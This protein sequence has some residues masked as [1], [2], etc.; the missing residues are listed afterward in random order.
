MPTVLGPS[1]R[2]PGAVGV[3][4]DDGRIVPLPP[5][6]V[7]R[8][9]LPEFQAPPSV[10][11]RGPELAYN[12]AT[13]PATPGPVSE[14]EALSRARNVMAPRPGAQNGPPMMANPVSG[15][16]I[17]VA[18][19]Q[20]PAAPPA[21]RVALWSGP[22]S[23]QQAQAPLEAA[24]PPVDPVAAGAEAAARQLGFA[25]DVYQQLGGD[26]RSAGPPSK[27]TTETTRE[28]KVYTPE[29]RARLMELGEKAEAA[30]TREV[31]AKAGQFESRA[32]GAGSMGAESVVAQEDIKGAAER[33]KKT[34][35][36]LESESRGLA[37]SAKATDAEAKALREKYQSQ[38][39]IMGVSGAIAGFI[40]SM[41][42][43]MAG[44]P[45]RT[46]ERVQA[47]L[48]QEFSRQLAEVEGLQGDAA[49]KRS[50]AA[51]L[52]SRMGDVA[53][54]Q[55]A[56]VSIGL[57][58][59]AV[60][61][62]GIENSTKSA[63]NAK[64][65]SRLRAEFDATAAEKG[66]EAVQASAPTRKTT[67]KETQHKGGRVGASRLSRG[68]ILKHVSENVSE[69]RGAQLK[70]ELA[71]GKGGTGSTGARQQLASLAKFENS[72]A[73]TSTQLEEAKALMFGPESEGLFGV[74]GV[75]RGSWANPSDEAKINRM[76]IQALMNGYIQALS[77]AQVS[78]DEAE[79]LV[80]G[81]GLDPG[82]PEDVIR[83]GVGR[84]DAIL[85]SKRSAFKAGIDPDVAE[86]Y[87]SR[88]KAQQAADGSAPPPGATPL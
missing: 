79:R 30:R 24:P 5:D 73:D 83:E 17:P 32:E 78:P 48:S 52:V 82:A 74:P 53:S 14:E 55:A 75:G 29:Q 76:K 44:T 12:G 68:D 11:S 86:L 27:L 47:M 63:E 46:T 23:A 33:A 50:A 88:K 60:G 2:E 6:Q 18:V 80:A 10:D 22:S 1:Q 58:S 4:T 51:D 69:E 43:A 38:R 65:A 25:E 62:E 56:F 35:E 36:Y 57:K 42:D 31:E 28:E 19:A 8:M 59:Y 71:S 61:L 40:G 81:A 39:T 85:E 66:M 64:R 16:T 7:Q 20:E 21:N 45:G 67:E 15:E 3:Q 49:R 9:G 41:G 77:G 37:E 13:L 26:G 87:Y 84:L 72:I 34:M 54:A 70:R